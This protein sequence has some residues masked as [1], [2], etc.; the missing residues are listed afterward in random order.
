M[1]TSLFF[2]SFQMMQNFPLIET[3]P[4]FSFGISI[5]TGS[6]RGIEERARELGI[7]VL[8]W[9]DVNNA[10]T[11]VERNITRDLNN[12]T[13]L[14]FCAEGHDAQSN[15]IGTAYAK[16]GMES[17]NLVKKYLT[18]EEPFSTSAGTIGNDVKWAKDIPPVIAQL[19]EVSIDFFDLQEIKDYLEA[20]SIL[21]LNDVPKLLQEI[22]Y[23]KHGY[24]QLLKVLD[25]VASTSAEPDIVNLCCD[26]LLITNKPFVPET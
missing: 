21:E 7:D 10:S 11:Q 1:G 14:L 23:L 25:E 4:E 8:D 19:L 18:H 12:I 15:L 24:K 20:E 3:P 9:N 16:V 13:G 22:R 26:V 5:S 17:W 2:V 6:Q